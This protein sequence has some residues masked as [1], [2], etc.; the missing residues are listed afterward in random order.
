LLKYL[1]SS[2][3]GNGPAASIALGVNSLATATC[4]STYPTALA[5]GGC[6]GDTR[7][8][9]F[10]ST[11]NLYVSDHS[12]EGIVVFHAPFTTGMNGYLV[13]GGQGCSSTQ[14][15]I[16]QPD[17]IAFDSSGNL[18]VADGSLARVMEFKAPFTA[19]ELASVVIGQ[20]DY[21]SRTCTTSSPASLCSPKGVA[22]DSSGNLWVSDYGSDRVLEFKA[23]F[24]SGMT[25]SVVIGTGT[26]TAPTASSLCGPRGIAFDSSGNLWV[27]DTAYNRILMFAPPYTSGASAVLGQSD[28]TSE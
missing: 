1:A 8:M 14:S 6:I 2:L 26:C 3:T 19:G 18:W 9:A 23:P 24:T 15:S 4:S 16:C 11:G 22:F 10:D 25:A 17:G 27:A 13:L 5:A 21:V 12:V 20:A 28:F 7:E